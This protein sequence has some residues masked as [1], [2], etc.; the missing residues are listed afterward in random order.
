MAHH[1]KGIPRPLVLER[2]A[3]FQLHDHGAG[4]KKPFLLKVYTVPNENLRVRH[5][6]RVLELRRSPDKVR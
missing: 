2:L 4:T 5:R 3:G 6:P 1:L